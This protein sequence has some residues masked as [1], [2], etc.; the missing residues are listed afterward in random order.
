[1]EIM[2]HLDRLDDGEIVWWAESEEQPLSAAA[3]TLFE[4]KALVVEVLEVEGWGEP[5]YTL[6]ATADEEHAPEYVER[7]APDTA[8]DP[9][10][11]HFAIA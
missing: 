6:V 11:L 3:P 1:M 7:P 2:I 10:A 5:S 4:L 8:P 9:T